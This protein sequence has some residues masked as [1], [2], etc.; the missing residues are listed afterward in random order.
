[1]LAGIK[2]N[3]RMHAHLNRL[4]SVRAVLGAGVGEDPLDNEEQVAD[5]M[6][7]LPYMCRFQYEHAAQRIAQR[8]DPLLE[9]YSKARTHHSSAV[10]CIAN[11]WLCAAPRPSGLALPLVMLWWYDMQCGRQHIKP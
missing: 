10:P 4:E 9:A 2:A 7:A 3:C 1:M 5:Q 11:P 6:D 8:M